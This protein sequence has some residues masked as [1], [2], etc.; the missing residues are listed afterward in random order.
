MRFLLSALPAFVRESLATMFQYR[1]EIILWAIW[2][3]VYPS[4]SMAMWSVAVKGTPGGTQ[5]GGYDARDFAGYFWL[6]MVIGHMCTAWDVYELGYFIQSG[7][8]SPRLLRPVLPVWNSVADNVAY[9]VVSLGVLVPIWLLIVVVTR[10]HFGADAHQALLAIPAILLA[11]VINY[12]WCYNL[13]MVAFWVTRMDAIGQAWFGAG[14]FFGGRLA[15]LSIMPLPLRKIASA[16]PFKWVIW[17]PSEILM[18]RLSPRTIWHGMEN[19]FAW[20]VFGLIVFRL[21]WR[22]GVRRYSAVGA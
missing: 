1:G 13:G 14:L 21:V 4:V 12:V 5:I 22:A 11:A 9:K 8:L 17:F 3:V 16:L 20:A 19:Q 10:P 15:P 7:K 6:T 18:G 2:G